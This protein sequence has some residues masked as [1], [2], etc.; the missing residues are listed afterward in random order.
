MDERDVSDVHH[1]A[2]P[3]SP[4][5]NE[6]WALIKPHLPPPAKDTAPGAQ[7]ARAARDCRTLGPGRVQSA[8]LRWIVERTFGWLGRCRRLA[9]DFEYLTRTH[10]AFMILAM[11]RIM[12]RRLV[13][14]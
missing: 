4:I 1:T 6:E 5:L 7:P 10:A 13:R 3:L 9:K 8:A 2:L 12:M 14:R 11:I